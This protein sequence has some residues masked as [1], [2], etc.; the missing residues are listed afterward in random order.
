MSESILKALMQLFAIIAHVDEDGVSTS[1]KRIVKSYLA[2][3]LNQRH[4]SEFLNLFEEYINFHHRDIT[5]NDGTKIRKRTAA[6]SVKVLMICR[7]INEELQQRQKVLVLLQLFEFIV[8]NKVITEKEL[9]FVT[10][11]ADIFN[12][13]EKEFKNMKAFTI[14]GLESAPDKSRIL[15]INGEK[16][17]AQGF[18][19][20]FNPG[21]IGEIKILNI[22]STNMYA[23]VYKGENDIYLNGHNIFPG[24]VNILDQG[25]SIR[26]P[27]IKP[28][29]YSDVATKF[30][31]ERTKSKLELIVKDVEFRFSNSENGIHKF[32]FYEESGQLVGIMGGSGVGK[33][34][35]LNVLNGNLP[36]NSG[37]ITI[38]GYDV[39]KNRAELNGV[40]GFVPQ[41]DLLIEELSV[42]QNLYYNAKLCFRELIEEEI[43]EKVD[44]ILYDLDLFEIRHLKVGGPL[45]KYIS[46]GQRKRLNIALELLREPS[47]LFVDEPTSGLSSMDSDMVMDLLKEQSLKGKLVIVNIHQPSSDIFKLFDT[48]IIMDKGG[49]PVYVGNPIDAVVYFKKVSNHVNAEESE[50]IRCGNV[51]PEQVLQVVEAKVVNEY[52]K[53]SRNR[54]ILPKEWYELYKNNLEAKIEIPAPQKIDLPENDFK[55]PTRLKQFRI[56]SVRN[57]LSKIAD[58]QYMLVNFF[59]A[60]LLAIILGYFT[61]FIAGSADNPNLYIFSQ[62]ENLP[63]YLFMSVVVAI[64]IGLTVSAEEI[65]K[66]RKILKRESFLNLSRFSYLNSKVVTLFVISAIQMITFVLLGN[67]ILGIKGMTF[68]YW[69]ILFSAAASANL[70]G[71][72]ISSAL[73]SVI[74]IY[75]L[76]PFILVPQ[77]L[78]SGVIVKF[79]KLHKNLAS[80]KYVPFVGDMMIS[81]WAYEALS[82]E[83]FKNNRYNKHFYEI[84]QKISEIGFKQNYII[85]ELEL[86][87]EKALKAV[88]G[89]TIEKQNLPPTLQILRTEFPGVVLNK[90]A[91]FLND[92]TEAKFNKKSG[93]TARKFLREQKKIFSG[94]AYDYNR[95]RDKKVESL[96]K[97]LGS[98]DALIELQKNY[99][100]EN[101][102]ELVQNKDEINKIFVT[103]NVFVQKADPIYKY[104]KSKFGRAHLYEK[105]KKIGN[106]NIETL[107]FNV[108]AMWLMSIVL[109]LTLWH[110]SLRKIIEF[111]GKNNIS[112]FFRSAFKKG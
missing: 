61:K 112:D 109:Y 17:D 24:R 4:V 93:V 26:S 63:G 55:L 37:K 40:V 13:T 15:L 48:L 107:W 23:F 87:I 31:Q 103:K 33:S 5:K 71:L 52:G 21:L 72:N 111:M 89:D 45:N 1:A 43:V 91:D 25:A 69:L 29:Y 94:I 98:K 54:K 50:C 12:I 9:D 53:L 76:I 51:N 80:H 102:T 57:I 75:I 110:D 20:I 39:Y 46:G 28:I 2:Q 99:H 88:D 42:F 106:F 68:S 38:N 65:I 8:E 18:K 41:D 36:P 56:F 95:E 49:F 70:I 44:E 32:N 66:D 11:V 19:H 78:L 97:K 77:L 27:K 35:L 74:T 7:Q 22:R 104:P 64:F 73:N 16:T 3:H 108:A 58:R 67:F 86:Y 101:L 14:D 60:P 82:V 90:K 96:I 100:N 105:E 81:R 6:N 59:E 85:P 79:D 10:T 34:T 62:N 84:E 92:F 30:L 83:Q 47:L